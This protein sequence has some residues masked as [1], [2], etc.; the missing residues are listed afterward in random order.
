[1]QKFGI[2]QPVTRV[3][4]TRLTTGHGSYIDDLNLED[5]AYAIFVRSPHAHALIKNTSAQRKHC[6][7]AV[8]CTHHGI[9]DL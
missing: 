3:E 8:V 6:T 9:G 4:D 5:Q 1:M 7:L 2:G